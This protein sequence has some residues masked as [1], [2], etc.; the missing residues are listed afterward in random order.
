MD[1]LLHVRRAR[2]DLFASWQRAVRRFTHWTE[3]PLVATPLLAASFGVMHAVTGAGD[4]LAGRVGVWLAVFGARSEEVLVLFGGR[5]RALVRAGEVWRLVTC[6]FLHGDLAHLFFN[7][8][9][10]YGLGRLCEAVFGPERL[11]WLFTSCVLGGAIASQ[12]GGGDLSVGASG[13]IFGMMGALV[14]FGLR[15]RRRMPP[16]LRDVFVRQL[17]PWIL[18]NLFIGA[19]LPFIDQYAHVGGLLAGAAQGLVLGDRITDRG[20]G[21]WGKALLI[22]AM[23]LLCGSA[24]ALMVS[25]ATP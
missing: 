4:Y 2:A 21:R 19:V 3:R 18:L 9:A 16:G 22:G 24:G 25:L 12:A 1:D 23:A 7:G 13:G 14:A 5:D 20:E 15:R 6:G 10:F 8:M 11:V 17:W